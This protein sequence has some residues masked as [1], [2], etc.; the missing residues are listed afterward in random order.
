MH[1]KQ[2]NKQLIKQRETYTY[3]ET[4]LNTTQ[5]NTQRKK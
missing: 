3:K 5:S 4:Q 2:I 1:K